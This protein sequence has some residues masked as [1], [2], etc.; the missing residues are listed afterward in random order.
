[1]VQFVNFFGTQLK[2]RTSA[3]Q[4]IDIDCFEEDICGVN[5]GRDLF[6]RTENALV[7][8]LLDSKWKNESLDVKVWKIYGRKYRQI[9]PHPL[10]EVFGNYIDEEYRFDE[11]P[12]SEMNVFDKIKVLCQFTQWIAVEDR[13]REKIDHSGVAA[14]EFRILPV[15]WK[16]EFGSYYLFDDNRLYYKEDH[17]PDIPGPELN[18]KAKSKSGKSSGRTNGKVNGKKTASR[19]AARNRV[20][21]SDSEDEDVQEEQDENVN[22]TLPELLSAEYEPSWECV[23]WDLESWQLLLKKLSKTKDLGEKELFKYLKNNV[24]PII[25]EYETTRRAAAVSREKQRAKVALVANRKRSSRLEE[26]LL[27]Q[28]QEEEEREKRRA[29]ERILERARQREKQLREIEE[30]RERRL[31]ERQE[32]ER[33]R[34]E[35]LEEQKRESEDSSRRSLRRK[36]QEEQQNWIFD[37]ICGVYGENYDDGT[38]SVECDNCNTWMHVDCLPEDDRQKVLQGMKE[39]KGNE[40]SD[41]QETSH[42]KAEGQEETA[43]EADEKSGDLLSESVQQ[44]ADNEIVPENGRFSANPVALAPNGIEPESLVKTKNDQ[45]KVGPAPLASSNEESKFI[46]SGCRYREKK[47]QKLQQKVHVAKEA[48]KFRNKLTKNG[49]MPRKRGRPPKYPRLEPQLIPAAKKRRQDRIAVQG[50]NEPKTK[51]PKTPRER[52]QSPDVH[53]N[54]EEARKLELERNQ[55]E[56]RLEPGLEVMLES[57]DPPRLLTDHIPSRAMQFEWRWS[58]RGGAMKLTSSSPPQAVKVPRRPSPYSDGQSPS[59]VA[60]A[61]FNNKAAADEHPDHPS[62]EVKHGSGFSVSQLL[63]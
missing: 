49:E 9:G 53:T 3:D 44:K 51:S 45:T 13:F 40:P 28:Q 16:G 46:C 22:T 52:R 61:T 8:H 27:R 30:A 47:R 25:E 63:N 14:E 11:N 54:L 17:V 23:C 31:L 39:S 20:V 2:I 48:Q 26:K 1:M 62:P 60:T 12:Y 35:L 42:V 41:D 10:F 59:S 56:N 58:S 4:Q 18:S 7:S 38:L 6:T 24:L 19:R 32:R 43:K 33:R 55:M 36:Q 29:E 5:P 21:S 37:C 50:E 57:V 34:R 15:G